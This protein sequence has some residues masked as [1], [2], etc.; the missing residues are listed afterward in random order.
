VELSSAPEP[1]DAHSDDGDMLHRLTAIQR[2]LSQAV[3]RGS[4]R[5]VVSAFVEALAVCEDVEVRGYIET[6]E[7]SFQLE[8]KLA[9][10]AGGSPASERLQPRL[11][12][13]AVGFQRLDS[14]DIERFQFPAG[15]DV[16]L[17]R[18]GDMSTVPWLL[19]FSGAIRQSDELRLLIYV[20]LLDQALRAVLSQAAAR[21]TWSILEHLLPTSD[22]VE[23]MAQ[24]ALAALN[25]TVEGAGAALVVIM[26]TGMHV[27]SLGDAEVFSV[28]RL[29]GG[30]D[31]IVATSTIRDQYSMTLAVRRLEGHAFTRR[32]RYLLDVAAPVFATW[33]SGVLQNPSYAK[34]R[35]GVLRRFDEVIERAA[36][37][38]IEDGGSV[39]LLL[40]RIGDAA[41]RAQAIRRWVADIRGQ[42]RS[43]DLAGLVS[44]NEVA[45]L[46]ADTSSDHAAIVMT[47]LRR[48]LDDSESTFGLIPAAVGLASYNAERPV[49]GSVLHA[50]RADAA[51]RKFA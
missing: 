50:A 40:F 31:E 49:A 28:P 48:Q 20:D 2:V 6:L 11:L 45:V 7:E 38:A 4:D 43:S 32:E 41:V 34:D 1:S 13:D 21:V 14:E 30:A 26:K 39:S 10:S 15:H 24:A 12:P 42:L 46:L 19:A 27:L 36:S 5:A 29:Y 47:R 18:V 22:R 23:Q 16:L 37:R 25:T 9:G 3:T 8:V 17:T 33:L 51:H 35:R 44:E